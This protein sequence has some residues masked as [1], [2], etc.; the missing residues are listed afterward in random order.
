MGQPHMTV[1]RKDGAA[2][3][4]L[5]RKVTNALNLELV[6]EL[7]ANLRKLELDGDTHG[8]VVTSANEK[9]FSIGF[10][11]PSLYDLPLEDFRK[12]YQTFNRT[13]MQLFS[14]PKPTIAAITG[15][16]VAGGCILALCCDYRYIAEG[17]RKMGL[18]EIKL[19]V[20]I[21]YPADCI[22]RV[23]VGFRTYREV[24]D[25]GDFYLPD[26]LINMGIV[27]RVVPV[28]LLHTQAI[29]KILSFG[30]DAH[31][32]FAMIKQNRV[33]PVLSGI[34]A[35]LRI[36]EEY[37]LTCWYSKTT[38]QKLQQAMTKF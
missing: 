15:H 10:D 27:D 17:N 34:Q 32:A 8:V 20:P 26:T 33:A 5:N 14:F 21:P 11:I 35:S 6:R 3:I 23:A 7:S 29:E 25:S 13:C 19:G 16:A 18:N 4:S 2:I 22:L 24:V 30:E 38:R 36:R 37:F 12:F 28:D 1:T 9:F 31:T